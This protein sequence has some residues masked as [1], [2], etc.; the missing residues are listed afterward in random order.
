MAEPPNIGASQVTLHH[1]EYLPRNVYGI[2]VNSLPDDIKTLRNNA[3][4]LVAVSIE[5]V[6]A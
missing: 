4:T 3:V 1:Q 5:F 6:E 2:P